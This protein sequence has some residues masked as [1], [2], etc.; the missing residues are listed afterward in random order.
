MREKEPEYMAGFRK[1]F[2]QLVR[3]IRRN[4]E[5]R[6]Y[7]KLRK[8]FDLLVNTYGRE[9]D[10]GGHQE[11]HSAIE[12][13]EIAITEIGLGMTSVLGIF[14][15]RVFKKGMHGYRRRSRRS[16]VNRLPSLPVGSIPFTSWVTKQLP[17]RRRIS[18]TCC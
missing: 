17:R 11:I 10:S 13:S 4:K 16:S 3:L 18:G 7:S 12:V 14:L 1:K 15:I 8:A 2:E 5:I 6:D 9:G